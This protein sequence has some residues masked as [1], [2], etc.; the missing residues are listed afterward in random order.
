M[1]NHGVA[2]ALGAGRLFWLFV[3]GYM[4][5]AV[6][7]SQ[8]APYT[9]T[10]AET[11]Q[12]V[13]RFFLTSTAVLYVCF[14]A[15]FTLVGY[16]KGLPAIAFAALATA[17]APLALYLGVPH[18]SGVPLLVFGGA[19]LLESR[20]LGRPA[21]LAGTLEFS[22]GMAAIVSSETPTVLLFA[23]AWLFKFR[24]LQHCGLGDQ[25]QSTKL[26]AQTVGGEREC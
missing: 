16:Q 10:T 11:V 13:G 6:S 8:S 4:G 17:A 12:D 5:F 19:L 24:L 9:G 1:V 18:V 26:S 22:S 15:G 14:H 20:E 21:A 7:A 25:R 3:I 2:I 23:V